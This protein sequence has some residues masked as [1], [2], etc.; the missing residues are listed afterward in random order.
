MSSRPLP[1]TP[2]VVLFAHPAYRHLERLSAR[3]HD[4]KAIEVRSLAD[5]EARIGEADVL[6]V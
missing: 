1:T 4:L 3:S 2:P 6:V 5:L